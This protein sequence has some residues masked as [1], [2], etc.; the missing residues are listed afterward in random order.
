MGNLFEHA[1]YIMYDIVIMMAR[2]EMG[3]PEEEMVARHRN[4][5]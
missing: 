1:L 2:E 5:E 4:I 3:I